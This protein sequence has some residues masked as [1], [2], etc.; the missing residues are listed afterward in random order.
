MDRPIPSGKAVL[1]S[2]DNF[3]HRLTQQTSQLLLDHFQAAA[4]GEALFLQQP[5]QFGLGAELCFGLLLDFD[6][7]HFLYQVHKFFSTHI[8]WAK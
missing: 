7:H 2:L 5:H 6:V 1:L 4:V 8:H 3:D